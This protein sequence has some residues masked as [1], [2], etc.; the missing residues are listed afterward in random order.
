MERHRP[1]RGSTLLAL[2][3]PV[4]TGQH[5]T[6]RQAL[7]GTRLEV[8][9]LARLVPSA[10]V[11][12]GSAASEQN[13]GQLASSGK[14]KSFRMLHLATH[15]EVD[16][17]DPRRSALILAQDRL[18]PRPAETV[19]RREK[20]LEGRLT[21]ETILRDWKLACDLVVLSACQSGLGKDAG[22]EG[23]LGFAQA[24]LAKGARSVVLSRW[25]VDDTA[26]ARLTVRFYENLLGKRKGLKQPLK[27]AEAL[28]EAKR[29]LAGLKRAD[30]EPLAARLGRGV[31]RGTEKEARPVVKG[32]AKL[33]DGERPFAHPYYWAAFVLIGDPS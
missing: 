23:L 26:T 10:T 5:G 11:L 17:R 1:L 16:R 28:A 9:A 2:G 30:A 20:L 24:F 7:P 13:L 14:L 21:V 18:P 27:R 12:L 32:E 31:L 29:W 25:K 19:L 4:F 3:D 6:G 8:Q 33:P 22:G 15:G